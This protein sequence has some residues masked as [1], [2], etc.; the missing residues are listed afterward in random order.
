MKRLRNRSSS[1]TASLAC[2]AAIGAGAPAGATVINSW[3]TS[4]VE[5]G[6]PV[7]GTDT[8]ASVV[9]DRSLPDPSATTNGQIVYTSPEA[10][11]PG[12]TV[13][14][15]GF[16]SGGNTFDGCI[17]ASSAADCD[18]GFQSGKRFKMQATSSGPVDLVFNVEPSSEDTLYRVFHRAIN[19]SGG[20]LGGFSIELGHGIG[21][22]FTRSTGSD[23]LSFSPSV[24]LGPDG[25]SSFSQ[26][27]FGLFGSLSN[28]NPNPLQL[29]GF[30]DTTSRAG[31]NVNQ[32]E[33]TIVSDGYYGIYDDL[34]GNWLS[35]EDVPDGLLWDYALGAA[36]PLVMA[37]DNGSAWEVRRGIDDALD[38]LIGTITEEDVFA[39][40]EA[41]WETFSYGDIDGVQSFLLGIPL[42]EDAIEDLAN[43]NL[44]FAIAM[45]SDF[46]RDSFTLRTATLEPVPLPPGAP[47][48]LGGVAVLGLL[49]RARRAP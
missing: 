49:R 27:P 12:L 1:L 44:N 8:G 22:D 39:L 24:S 10:N 34:F 35:Q 20:P 17:L 26:Y 14:Q 13:S 38:G 15:T 7:A 25:L 46:G 19:V 36:D 37:W 30:F 31:F 9:Y 45:T 18:S 4:N 23:G 33:D 40:D 16:S 21:S 28:P 29:P 48:L 43:L 5:V 42:F 41:D 2:L 32:T 6:P 47:L 11:T 3:N